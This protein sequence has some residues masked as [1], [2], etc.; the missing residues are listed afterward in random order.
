MIAAAAVVAALA[1]AGMVVAAPNP[2][3]PSSTSVFNVGAQCSIKWDADTLGQWKDMNIQLMTGDNWNM[4]PITTVAQNIDA[5]KETSFTYPCPDV[6]PNSAIYFYQFSHPENKTELLWTTRFTIADAKG[7]TTPPTET[8]QPDGQSIPWGKGALT[9][10]ST[11]VPPPAYLTG[12][13][14]TTPSTSGSS[15]VSV[16]PAST[17][18]PASAGSSS[19]AGSA[20]Q[21]LTTSRATSRPASTG[22]SSGTASAAS[23]TASANAAI[24]N[25][26]PGV[27]AVVGAAFAAVGLF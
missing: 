24:G 17:S 1:G 7:A 14:G 22:T 19:A 20:T 13:Q 10:P 11:A 9:D 21:S 23:S 25:V 16:A 27:M 5:T 8:T 18:A 15:S 2:T 12:T 6:T 3:E 26:A 4:I